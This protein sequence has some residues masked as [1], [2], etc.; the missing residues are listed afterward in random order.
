MKLI[1]FSYT[2]FIKIAMNKISYN[3][4]EIKINFIEIYIEK[5]DKSFY[6]YNRR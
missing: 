6:N 2:K 3:L 1:K 5:N 4:F